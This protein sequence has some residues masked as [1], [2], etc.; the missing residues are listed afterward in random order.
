MTLSKQDIFQKIKKNS[1]LLHD[2]H[3]KTIGLFG[4]FVRNE[5][6]KKS[7]IDM[8]VE[9]EPGVSLLDHAK[10]QNQLS[11]LFNRDVDVLS[12]SGIKPK[13]KS[14]ILKEVE[15]IEKY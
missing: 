7:D 2:Y 12:L 8:V 5:Q 11:D 10:F 14:Y 9:F 15:W 13:L 6:K 4:S 1:R 3:I